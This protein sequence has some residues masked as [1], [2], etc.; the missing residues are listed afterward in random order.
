[1]CFSASASF[2]AGIVLAVIG[3]A[4]IKKREQPSQ[5]YFATIPFLFSIQQISEGFLWLA[6]QNPIFSPLEKPAIYIFLFLAQVVWPL[7]LPLAVLKLEQ[8]K[9]RK[10]MLLILLA[11]GMLVSFYLAYCLFSYNVQAKIVGYHI[12]YKQVYPIRFGG[13]GDFLYIAATILP[14]LISSSKR[15]WILGIII[16]VSYII[17]MFYYVDNI[18]S[19]W[20]FFASAISFMVL[21]ILQLIKNKEEKPSPI[22]QY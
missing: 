10:K 18:I 9:A 13:Y 5:F 19:V 3:V 8:E 21:Y 7:W 17:T 11:I 15:I 4:T 22:K 2:G 12:S 6:L 20:C 14:P 16:L 1:M